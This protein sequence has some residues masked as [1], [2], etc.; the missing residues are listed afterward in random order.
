MKHKI[1]TTDINLWLYWCAQFD[2]HNS[3]SNV[4]VTT[5]GNILYEFD[6]QAARALES[7]DTN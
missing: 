2:N 1:F 5:K 6:K 3:I 4:Y 7:S